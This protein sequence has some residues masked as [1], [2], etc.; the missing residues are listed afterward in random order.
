MDLQLAGRVALV[1]GAS[2]GIGR[3]IAAALAAEGAAVVISARH[4]ADITAAAAQIAA[5]SGAQV[6]GVA[7]DVSQPGTAE[8]LVGAAVERF[9]GLDILVNNSGGP[10][11]GHVRRLRR[12][13]LAGRL[14]PAAAERGPDG[15]GRAGRTCRP[16]A[17]AGSSTSSRR[18]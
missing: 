2:R 5:A 1:N 17:G 15:A 11:L 18:R 14:R 9:G 12:R 6:V 10:P 8:R 16:A 3:A 13:R 4:E 7:A